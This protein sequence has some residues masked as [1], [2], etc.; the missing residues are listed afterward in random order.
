MV[1]PSVRRATATEVANQGRFLPG[2][3]QSICQ[4]SGRLGAKAI[5]RKFRKSME[6]KAL[7]NGNADWAARSRLPLPVT[8]AAY[9]PREGFYHYL[10][11]AWR[12]PVSRP[13]RDAGCGLSGHSA[14]S[15]YPQT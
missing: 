2:T 14:P 7:L 6:N 3:S 13:S 15:Q 8:I 11:N 10:P 5:G 12:H 9:I 4:L 1:V